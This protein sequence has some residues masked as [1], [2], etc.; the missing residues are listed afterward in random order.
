MIGPCAFC[1]G[2]HSFSRISYHLHAFA[3]SEQCIIQCFQ[4]HPLFQLRC[5]NS[6]PF[7]CLRAFFFGCS[8][9]FLS[10]IVDFNL[11]WICSLACCSNLMWTRSFMVSILE[12]DPWIMPE[13]TAIIWS[14]TNQIWSLPVWS[15][16]IVW[17]SQSAHQCHDSWSMISILLHTCGAL[18]DHHHHKGLVSAT[19]ILFL[20]FDLSNRL[21]VFRS[22]LNA[23]IH[24]LF[25]ILILLV[26]PSIWIDFS[27]LPLLLSFI[28][29]V[30][31]ISN[32]FLLFNHLWCYS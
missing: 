22:S 30:Q 18:I 17:L 9:D 16:M 10:Q 28:G 23:S 19:W 8:L 26:R 1:S 14:H 11:F 27:S 29:H 20:G 3:A 12:I 25:S 4:F 21:H 2:P 15:N 24:V 5:V 7:V 13:T 6:T 31:T 32:K